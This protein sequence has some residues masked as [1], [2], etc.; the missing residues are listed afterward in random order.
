MAANQRSELGMFIHIECFKKLIEGME[1]SLGAKM[2]YVNLVNAGRQ[3][4][5][6]VFQ[7][8][9]PS[10]DG[11]NA[12]AL[13]DLLNNTFGQNGTKLCEIAKVEVEA[14]KVR[15]FCKE[16]IESYGKPGDLNYTL[17]AMQGLL[18]PL[19]SK[20]LKGYQTQFVTKGDEFDTVEYLFVG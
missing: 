4:G 17:G 6:D 8:N 7:K 3:R 20:T 5:K 9:N 11:Q 16:A 13:R 2:A 10:W 12:E 18:E 1:D 14:D 19:M 15:V